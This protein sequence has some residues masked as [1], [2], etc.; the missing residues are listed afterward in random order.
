MR[1]MTGLLLVLATLSL[2]PSISLADVGGVNTMG[3]G[4][5]GASNTYSSTTTS[6][7][8]SSNGVTTVTTTVSSGRPC[9]RTGQMT[10]ITLPSS[11]TATF[12]SPTQPGMVQVNSSTTTVPMNPVCL[13]AS[14]TPIHSP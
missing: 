8:S 4:S 11:T 1:I 14:C 9:A 10:Y 2:I 7:G 3:G 12:A 6:F 13:G 5:Y